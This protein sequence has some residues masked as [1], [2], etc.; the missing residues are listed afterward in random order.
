MLNVVILSIIMLKFTMIGI[1][2]LSVIALNVLAPCFFNHT[3]S[4]CSEGVE[5]S[6][7][8]K[9]S[10][11]HHHHTEC[12]YDKC[13]YAEYPYVECHCQCFGTMLAT[14]AGFFILK[15]LILLNVVILSLYDKC[16]Y[17]E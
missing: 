11:A 2:M 10:Y 6:P 13:S 8:A 16:I 7:Y 15:V 17:P 5:E 4:F 14:L 9:C 12:H 1:V 3:R